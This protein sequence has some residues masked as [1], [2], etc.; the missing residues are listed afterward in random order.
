MPIRKRTSSKAKNGI[1]YEVYFT[2]KQNGITMRYS[3]S[4]FATK[5]EAKDHEALKKAEVQE[6]GKIRKEVKKTFKDVYEEFLEVEA[7]KYQENTIYDMKKHYK[8]CEKEISLI[9]IANMDYLLLQKFFNSRKDKSFK[10][11][12][13]IKVAISRILNYAVKT[14]YIKS[15]PCSLIEIYGVEKHYNHDNIIS[16]DNFV[17]LT[18]TLDE[19]ED[20]NKKAQSIAIKIGYY[21]G[22]RASEV[23]AL[24]KE[25]IDFNYNLINVNKKLV[26]CGLKKNEIYA[27]NKMKSKK[28][29]AIIPL[30]TP[31][32]EA[33]I[34]WFEINPYN[35][36]ICD[37]NGLYLNPSNFSSQVQKATEELNISFHFHMLRHTFATNLVT[38]N[39]DLKTAQELMRHSDINTTISVYT[40]VN[41]QHKLNV[42]NNIFMTKSVE[43]VSSLNGEKTLN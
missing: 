35:K 5:K 38:N 18:D 4:G 34:T 13:G 15:N 3:K 24:D 17:K 40:H 1:V 29:K 37:I 41:N 25:D 42:I 26:Y 43:N 20:F 7:E 16:Y 9:P 31:L 12:K 14:G 28:S 21:T 30:A 11:N 19:K 8:Y 39:V 36:V 10:T 33:L 22:L 32:K 23:F 27:T 2:Y 6:T